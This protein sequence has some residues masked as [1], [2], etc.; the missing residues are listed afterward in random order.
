MNL[1]S[2]F[3]CCYIYFNKTLKKNISQVAQNWTCSPQFISVHVS[4]WDHPV[5]FQLPSGSSAIESGS[6]Q[7]G[8]SEEAPAFT[9]I[10]RESSE[11]LALWGKLWMPGTLRKSLTAWHFEE[12][13]SCKHFLYILHSWWCNVHASLQI[14]R[15]CPKAYLQHPLFLSDVFSLKFMSL[16]K[17]SI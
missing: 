17:W 1:I 13:S 16:K 10:E 8:F 3:D 11:C 5:Q 9:K 12:S 15:E 14:V 4:L 6:A 2:C 7:P